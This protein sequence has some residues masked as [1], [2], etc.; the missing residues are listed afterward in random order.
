M[1]VQLRETITWLQKAP[2]QTYQRFSKRKKKK[3]CQINNLLLYL[4]KRNALTSSET[5]KTPKDPQK[6]SKVDDCRI[7][8]MIHNNFITEWSEHSLGKVCNQENPRRIHLK[9][10][11]QM[12]KKKLFYRWNQDLL[13]P[14]GWEEKSIKRGKNRIPHYL[15]LWWH[16]RSRAPGCTL[17]L[18]STCQLVLRTHCTGI[19][20]S[21]SPQWCK[22]TILHL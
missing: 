6:T 19:A 8:S 17:V 22:N 2:K 14:E 20:L 16:G 9:E 15:C 4:K 7:I 5:P 1:S 13:V 18:S 21:K 3:C 12:W 11:A 10:P